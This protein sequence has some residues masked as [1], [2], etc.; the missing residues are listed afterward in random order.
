MEEIVPAA[1][2]TER[3]TKFTCVGKNMTLEENR[4]IV[5]NIINNT[6]LVNLL[7]F[8]KNETTSD[9]VLVLFYAPY[10]HFCARIG[11]SYNALAR[12]F[13]QLEIVAVDAAQFSNLNAKFGTVSVPNII[14]FHQSRSAVR[15]NQTDKSF[16]N[17][18]EFV[19]NSTGLNPNM[20]VNITEE[21]QIGPLPSVPVE[22]TD[23]LLWLA[24]VF[25]VMCS[26]FM[27]IHSQ[28]GQQWIN[29]VKIL[30]QEHQHIE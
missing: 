23:Y 15:F 29:K 13:P 30:W 2:K 10:C 7:S 8:D 6:R 12:V 16:N 9:C 21:D 18:I 26:T 24:W 5:V 17:L 4:T 20:T 28:K 25:V 11:P 27:F 1:N 19:K 22:S 14:L 3:K